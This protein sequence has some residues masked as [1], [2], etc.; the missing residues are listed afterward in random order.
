LEVFINTDVTSIPE[1]TAGNYPYKF[2]LEQNYPNPFNPETTIKYQ[3]SKN[4]NVELIVYNLA[5]QIVK[6]LVNEQK[7]AGEY[8][9][10][11]NNNNLNSGIY[12]YRISA[13]NYTEV[14]KCMLIK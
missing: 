13:G 14:K 10:N 7:T 1:P 9:V 11:W 2:R 5:G 4:C 3:I 8:S 12:F 6:I